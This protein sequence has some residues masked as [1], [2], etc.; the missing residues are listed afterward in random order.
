MAQVKVFY[1]PE[2]ALLTVFWQA[3]RKGQMGTEMGDGVILIKDAI[4]GEAIGL[5]ILSYKPG[6]DR[7]DAV[8]V[9]LGSFSSVR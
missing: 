7:F 3:P 5:E 8:T 9:E 4:T 1:D 2:T 6:D